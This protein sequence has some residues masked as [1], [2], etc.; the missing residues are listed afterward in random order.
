[1]S[2]RLAL[3]YVDIR[4]K[5]ENLKSDLR[6]AENT[7]KQSMGT[8][9]DLVASSGGF[10]A[11]MAVLR[12]GE[13]L[14]A[15]AETAS[16]AI[17]VIL[18]DSE[19][20]FN[21]LKQV[22][23]FSTKTPFTP[24]ELKAATQSMLAF[25]VASGDIID[26]L[27]TLGDISAGSNS[28]LQEV[29]AVFNKIRATGKLTGETY[30]QLAERGINVKSTLMDMLGVTADEF[31][32]MQ[33]KGEI[34]FDQV[35]R[36]MER[37]TTE[38]GMFFDAMVQQSETW[39]GKMSTLEGNIGLIGSA[40][41]KHL[42]EN[43][44]LV[45]DVVNN[46]LVGFLKL[47]NAMGGAITQTIAY[48]SAMYTLTAAIIAARVAMKAFGL[49]AATAMKITGGA[50]LIAVLSGIVALVQMVIKGVNDGSTTFKKWKPIIDNLRATWILLKD[51][52]MDLFGIIKDLAVDAIG[53]LDD[54]WAQWFKDMF[55]SWDDFLEKVTGV[56]LTVAAA[57]RTYVGRFD[58]V[59]EMTKA[60]AK[61]AAYSIVDFFRNALGA[62]TKFAVG[63]A[64]GVAHIFSE[65]P[66]SIKATLTGESGN[67]VLVA[68]A[69]RARDI[70]RNEMV[71]AFT[72]GAETIKA[73]GEFNKASAALG[74]EFK[75]V[76]D[77]AL[78][79][80]RAAREEADRMKNG[81]DGKPDAIDKAVMDGI[82]LKLDFVAFDDLNKTI[83]D[84]FFKK[85]NP[86][87]KLEDIGNQQ[88]KVLEKVEQKMGMVVGQ[89]VG[90]E[91]VA[92][93]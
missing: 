58:L 12:W 16:T 13:N 92:E 23:E 15:Q 74:L 3:A 89:N 59:W 36:A 71:G 65:I 73:M 41:G 49:T 19:K 77:E 21:L 63:W 45:V 44:K 47:D 5:N 80:A 28:R 69:A 7:T 91:P 72:P 86:N 18:K 34:S 20:T 51:T 8:I 48:S 38:G 10:L 68:A 35:L 66:E 53:L 61:V 25:G 30:L 60:G 55:N 31:T 22:D 46:M 87:A 62:A 84:A 52:V 14:A 6:R 88:L 1:M 32:E 81:K 2:A 40:F 9:S 54:S 50:V 64:K 93:N 33:R 82:E 79:R 29:V 11:G 78:A 17:N 4:A 76:R 37:M 27:K 85:D 26:R 83:Q 56:L 90:R 24:K 57:F 70:L 75:R 67:D 42:I 43:G 39:A